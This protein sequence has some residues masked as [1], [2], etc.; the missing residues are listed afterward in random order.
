M[1]LT[2]RTRILAVP[3][4]VVLGASLFAVSLTWQVP[5]AQGAS[6]AVAERNEIYRLINGSRAANG[7]AALNVDIFL[8]SKAT[9]GAIPCPD[10]S[11]KTIGGRVADMFATG[12]MS[13]Y[14]R[15]CD[16]ATYKDSTKTF[17]STMQTA[18]GYG[19][20][21]EDLGSNTGYGTGAY[22][23]TYKSF[24]TSTYSTT[25]HMMA[26]WASSSTHW[27]I[28]MGQYNRVGCGVWAGGSTYEY[29]CEFAGG[30]GPAPMG[31]RGAPRPAV[32]V[33]TPAPPAP[34]VTA[35]PTPSNYFGGGYPYPYTVG[36]AAPS[37]PG[38][39]A[40]ASP[41]PAPTPTAAVQALRIADATA[42]TSTAAAAGLQQ[43]NVL[44]SDA[45]SPAAVARMVAFLA[46]S[47]VG[48]LS[49]ILAL[50]S[51]RRRRRETVL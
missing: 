10:D 49:A 38:Q 4:A 17:V 8:E 21:G 35:A 12:V 39:S 36:I 13:H 46:G 50:I 34:A 3:A 41:T 31:L 29:A 23:F 9:D 44:T 45:S 40:S 11:A 26:G 20:V 7:K 51:M 15:L 30:S 42:T 19:S 2:T 22:T 28:I 47:L 6:A 33:R 18:W 43:N 14:L 48:V 25:G 1:R 24:Q 32:T 27:G 5:T 16:A 37:T